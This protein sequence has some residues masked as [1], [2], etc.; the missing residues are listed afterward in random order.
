MSDIFRSKENALNDI[1]V[2][3]VDDLNQLQALRPFLESATAEGRK[4]NVAFDYSYI[5][6]AWKLLSQE[7]GAE[8]KVVEVRRNQATVAVWPL[9][10][11]HGSRA[12][13]HLGSGSNEEYAGLIGRSI[14]APIAE[15]AV[16]W[17]LGE[18]DMLE[19]YNLA[20]S[21]PLSLALQRTDHVKIKCTSPIITVGSDPNAWR[22]SKSKSFRQN[23]K[24]ARNRLSRFGDVKSGLVDPRD[25]IDFAKWIFA[26]KRKWLL[27]RKITQN[28]LHQTL[29]HVFFQNMMSDFSSNVR[30]YALTLDG[31]YVAGSIIF[32]GDDVEFFVVANDENYKSFSPGQLLLD[33]LVDFAADRGSRIDLRLNLEGYKLRW[34]DAYEDRFTYYASA[35][36]KGRHQ[37]MMKR[38]KLT[39]QSIRQ[40]AGGW[41]RRFRG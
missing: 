24:N 2:H 17:A 9:Y 13:R 31:N 20:P 29:P 25:G 14:D 22:S 3:A 28:W 6:T 38:L 4:H 32:L 30:G 37:V 33:G 26:T 34:T 8:L 1:T 19:V 11:D 15:A 41:R 10:L 5:L 23:I 36:L 27:D 35:T 21:D 16:K 12:M 39:I 18:C 7:R 40:V